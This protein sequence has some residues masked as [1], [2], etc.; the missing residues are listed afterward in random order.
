MIRLGKRPALGT[1]AHELG[2]HLVNQLEPLGVPAHG[3]VWVAWFDV[4]AAGAV[5]WC[6]HNGY[7]LDQR[8]RLRSKGTHP[9]A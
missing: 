8:G 6:H 1:I 4:A 9:E 5:E 3:R 7:E 2:H